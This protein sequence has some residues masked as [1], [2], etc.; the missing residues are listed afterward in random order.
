MFQSTFSATAEEVDNVTVYVTPSHNSI[1]CHAVNWL[2]TND[3]CC[4]E[5]FCYGI[6]S[7]TACVRAR[8]GE[9]S[10][11]RAYSQLVGELESADETEKVLWK[12]NERMSLIGCAF[13]SLPIKN[14]LVEFYVYILD[15][16]ASLLRSLADMNRL[17]IYFNSLEKQPGTLQVWPEGKGEAADRSPVH[18]LWCIS[19]K[20]FT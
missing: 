6:V 18:T 7:D 14:I 13:V 12:F 11:Y 20:F 16:D 3:E 15:E 17:V 2:F 4:T 8:R 10:Q 1:K 5:E 9:L 19:T